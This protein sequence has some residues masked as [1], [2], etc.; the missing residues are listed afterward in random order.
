MLKARGGN[1]GECPN[2]EVA[3]PHV[4]KLCEIVTTSGFE[5]AKYSDNDPNIACFWTLQDK[6]LSSSYELSVSDA[7]VLLGTKASGDILAIAAAADVVRQVAVGDRVTYVLNRN[8]NFTNVCVRKCGFCAFSRTAVDK[9]GYWLPIEEIVRRAK[10]AAEYG[11]TEVCV[12]AG[13]PPAMQPD[14]YERT[15]R[16]VKSELP[17]I[18][19][20]GFS[21]EEVKY[22][23]QRNGVSVRDYLAR[24]KDAG[25]GS[26]PGTS[27]EILDDSVRAVIAHGRLSTTEWLDIVRQSHKLGIR[28]TSTMMYGHVESDVH[29]AEHLDLIRS[30]QKETQGFSEFVPLSFVASDAPM[31]RDQQQH[32]RQDAE[33]DGGGC[34]ST[35]NSGRRASP[36]SAVPPGWHLREGPSGHDVIRVHAVSRLMLHPHINNIQA[37]WV[38][39]GLRMAE[40]LLSAGVNDLGGTLINESISTSAG[41]GH[42]QLVRPSTLRRVIRSAGRTPVQRS[43]LY[44]VLREYPRDVTPEQAAAESANEPLQRWDEGDKDGIKHKFGSFFELTAAK[45]WRFR[46]AAGIGSRRTAAPAMTMTLGAREASVRQMSTMATSPA[47][48][49]GTSI[50]TCRTRRYPTSTT[51]RGTGIPLQQRPQPTPAAARELARHFTT[52]TVATAS[53]VVTYSPSYTIVP[54]FEC[55][56]ACTYCNFR[57]NVRKDEEEWMGVHAARALLKRLSWLSAPQL[58]SSL[59]SITAVPALPPLHHVHAHHA[60]QLQPS[61]FPPSSAPVSEILVLSGEVSPTS[62]RREEWL[63]RIID[64]CRA[65]LDEGMLP[66]T[67]AGPLTVNE[68]EAVAQVNVSMGL[69]LEQV[70]PAL[71]IGPSGVHRFAPSKDPNSRIEQLRQAGKLKIPFTT[72]ILCGIGENEEDRTASLS[73]IADIAT[74]YGH[75]GEV[76]IQPYQPGSKQRAMS[77]D[78]AGP[79]FDS[80]AM[81]DLVRKARSILPADVVIQ[82]PPNL[83]KHPE[84]LLDC[85]EAGASDLGG[86]GPRDEVNPDHEFPMMQTLTAALRSAGYTM[87][88]RLPLYPRHY[89]WVP[90][91]LRGAL[92]SWA[93]RHGS[94]VGNAAMGTGTQQFKIVPTTTSMQMRAFSSSSAASSASADTINRKPETHEQPHIPR[95]IVGYHPDPDDAQQWVAELECGHNQHVRH[96]PPMV[97]RP[98]TTTAEGRASK[99]GRRLPCVKCVAGAPRDWQVKGP[100]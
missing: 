44:D 24:L 71:Q 50:H 76:I 79:G 2:C 20:H 90:S 6:K 93:H 87:Q 27:A 91:D 54:T 84:V 13:L 99:V 14:L 80:R 68:M 74:A 16:A 4:Q 92:A 3:A 64:I 47:P 52:R 18:H 21:P 51:S 73:V 81:P 49:Q 31:F 78:S 42:G 33:H 59:R 75:I 8:I 94:T 70:A 22:G 10:Q 41:A 57:T 17:S 55:F 9:E 34:G 1:F 39:E 98:W 66:H 88:P 12:Q 23:A 45:E 83:V 53:T 30:I 86:I 43:T 69:M 89:V 62:P 85:I 40:I 25:V 97:E 100:G 82:I 28:T 95:A 77:G 65:V 5:T 29:V 37:S 61:A 56:N 72:G 36:S 35:I 46:D 7:I 48:K 38:K 15:I 60:A 67:S 96:T 32:Q 58:P 63:Q 11:A 26:L 19:I